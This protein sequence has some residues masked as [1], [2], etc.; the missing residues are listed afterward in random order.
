MIVH[1]FGYIHKGLGKAMDVITKSRSDKEKIYILAN[2]NCANCAAKIEDKLRTLNGIEDAS[3][4]LATQQLFLKG[5]GSGMEQATVQEICDSIENGVT[6]SEYKGRPPVGSETKGQREN[7]ESREGE[8]HGE[9]GHSHAEGGNLLYVAAGFVILL[10]TQFTSWVSHPYDTILIL[11]AYALLGGDVLWSAGRNLIKGNIFDENFLMSLATIGAV[12]IGE[13]PE[14]L[15][16]MLFYKIGT[17]FEERATERSRRDIMSAI[18]MRPEQVRRIS[19]EGVVTAIKTEE[20]QVGD[21]LL[22]KAGDRIPLDGTVVSGESRIDTAPITGEPVPV[23]VRPD[24]PVM[25]GCIN[26]SGVLTIRADKPL[27]ESMVSRILDSVEHAAAS[28]PRIDRFITRFA[29]SYTP[30]VVLIALITAIVP[31][32][33]TGNWEYWI[34]TALTFLVISCPCALVISIPLSFFAGIGAGS[35]RGILFKGGLAIE[36]LKNIKMVAMDKTGTITTGEFSV[37]R[38]ITSDRLE[39]GQQRTN[40]LSEAELQEGN[41][42]SEAELLRLAAAVEANSTHPIAGSIVAEAAKRKLTLQTAE[43]V[44]EW[45]GEGVEGVAE[46]RKILCGNMRLLERFGIMIPAGVLTDRS[47][48]VGS[49]IWVGVDGTFA[50]RIDISDRLKA[51]AGSAVRRL[52]EM[53]LQTGLLTGDREESAVYIAEEVGVRN[54][55]ARL[56]PQDKVN[57]LQKWRQEIGPVL[58]VGDGINDAPVLAGA[59]VG[60]AMGSGAEAAIEAADVVF[61]RSQVTAI[62]MA[63]SIA[64]ETLRIAWQNVIFALVIKIA[65]MLLGLMGYASM[66]A[67]VFADTGVTIICILNAIRILYKKF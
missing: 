1:M 30:A 10:V 56:L 65:I 32:L 40:G 23:T 36:A 2:L 9:E 59:D 11:L 43:A 5:T 53:G 37:Q 63:L 31:P 7:D 33:F 54:V 13:Y 26:L 25:S 24:A 6:V 22:V 12:L 29:R 60:A 18:D 41:K 55:Q 62:P 46:G 38:I 27:E 51:D 50:G 35:R 61:M 48:T 28:K 44:R 45:S 52:T 49:V 34:Y 58:F 8:T 4:T 67:A 47:E 21:L 16:V 17:Y 19:P 15:G 42:L 39:A 14:A 20:A 66:W 57:A 64:D 3:F